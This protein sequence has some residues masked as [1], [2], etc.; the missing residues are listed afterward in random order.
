MNSDSR[1]PTL[2][3][4]QLLGPYEVLAPLGAGGMGEVYRAR[5]T[6]LDREVA[7]KV[8]PG[9]LSRDPDRLR[10]FE[11]EARAT[12][13]LNHPNILSVFDIGR[14]EETPFIVFELLEGVTLR[15]RL[16]HGELPRR[17]VLEWATQIARGLAAAHD[18]GI[19]HRDLKPE[20]LFVTTDGLVKILDFGLAKLDARVSLPAEVGELPTLSHP[21]SAG[22]VLGTVGY[23][24]PEQIRGEPTDRRSD[25]FSFGAILYEMMSGRRAFTASTPVETMHAILKDEP[26]DLSAPGQ[27]VLP[28]VD[29]IV[30]RCLAKNPDERFQS[31]RDLAFHLQSLVTPSMSSGAGAVPAPTPKRVMLVVLP[32]ENLSR[33]PEQEYF[34][35]GLTEETIAILGEHAPGRLGVIARTSAMSYKGSRKSVADIGRELNVAFVV[36]GSVRRHAERVRITVQL[37]RTSD[38]TQVWAQQYDRELRDFLALQGELGQAIASQVQE[39]LTPAEPAAGATARPVNQAAYD[40]YLHGRFHLWRVTRTSLERAIA[41]FGQATEIDPDMAAAYAGLAQAHV[42]LPVAADERPTETFARA[43]QAAM[44]ALAIEP[45]SPEAHTALA[46]LRFWHNWD[47]AACE[48]HARRAI[49]RNPSYSRAHQVLGRMLT[50]IGRYQEAAAE[51]DLARRLDPFAALINTLAAEFRFQA[52]RHD[53]ALPL[54]ERA[55]EIDANFWVAHVLL[56]KFHLHQGRLEEG[57]QAAERARDLSGGHSEPI[58]LIGYAYGLMGRAD[59]ARQ[60]LTHLQRLIEER[61]VPASSLAVVHL[62]LGE[63]DQTIRWLE[64]AFQERDVRLLDLAVEPKW[65]VLRDHPGFQS[66]IRRIGLQP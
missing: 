25:I 7:V 31:A 4:G 15:D 60:I 50:N 66:L 9:E 47:W 35:D 54:L 36:E 30:R 40:A 5:D 41:Y 33:D 22:M 21:T 45:D 58:S 42:I 43:E 39:R 57:V 49:A 10:R 55:L 6:R 23:M 28:A 27:E 34:S 64:R 24:S 46:S 8:L 1:W 62:G 14:V 53:E 63:T 11:Q 3:T 32:F 52:R 20:N 38:Q 26:P 37:I 19:V 12:S 2:Q 61:Y 44:R 56:A 18:K 65:D 48:A 29:H 51:I 59:E 17:T 16:R 13:R